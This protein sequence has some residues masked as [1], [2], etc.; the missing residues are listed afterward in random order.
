MHIV[1]VHIQIPNDF[2]ILFNLAR[3]SNLFASS[4]PRVNRINKFSKAISKF[5]AELSD[6]AADPNLDSHIQFISLLQSIGVD[7][8][9]A[10][11]LAVK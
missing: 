11:G 10:V 2:I 1:F 5:N 3:R 8:E 7:A 9:S 4:R 6:A